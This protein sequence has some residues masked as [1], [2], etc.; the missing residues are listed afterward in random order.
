[1]K[2]FW[3]PILILLVLVV[4]FV[5]SLYWALES[6]SEDNVGQIF[7][8]VCVGIALV[9]YLAVWPSVYGSVAGTIAELKAFFEATKS[10]YEYAVRS[11]QEIEIKALREISVKGEAAVTDKLKRLVDVDLGDLAYL[12]LGEATS[13]RVRDF[14]DKVE[15]YNDT[16][17]R[18]R[19]W[20]QL[21]I[22]R[23]FIPDVPEDLK[24][25][26]L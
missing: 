3:F 23:G 19:W 21:S 13:R 5:L 10:A 8:A 6:G 7:L 20:E 16:L 2:K 26:S 22:T 18:Y 1:M 12:N 4:G 24:F 17:A 14:R 11:T 25:V 15:E 9:I